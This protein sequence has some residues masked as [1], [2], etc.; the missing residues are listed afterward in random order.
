MINCKFEGRLG[1]NLFQIAT[2]IAKSKEL[3]VDF[4]LPFLTKAGHRGALFVDLSLFEYEFNRTNN[5]YNILCEEG[6]DYSPLN[7][8]SDGFTLKGF[9]QSYQYFDH[10]KDQLLNQYFKFHPKLVEYIDFKYGDNI[11]K[12]SLAI[13]IRRGDFLKLQNNHCVLSFKY[14]QDTL[15]EY[16]PSITEE[17]KD[18]IDNIFIFSDDIEYCKK[19]FGEDVF[20]IEEHSNVQLALLSRFSNHIMSNSTFSWWGSY[21]NPT[22]NK[23][24][25]PDPWFGQANSNLNVKGLYYPSWISKS[26]IIEHDHTSLSENQ[27]YSTN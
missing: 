23:I 18:G 7:G 10:I 11:K 12:N 22:P 9:F 17:F 3:G 25:I 15:N 20:Y 1:N 16:F 13:S 4:E 2:I 8:L 14:Y 5:E 24:I 6:F 21:L 27:F 19:L 26:H